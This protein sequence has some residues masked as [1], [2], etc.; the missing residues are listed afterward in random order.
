MSSDAMPNPNALTKMAA[1]PPRE[2]GIERASEAEEIPPDSSLTPGRMTKVFHTTR[3]P[4][5]YVKS[6]AVI[7]A[8]LVI[9]GGLKTVISGAGLPQPV[10]YIASV[11]ASACLLAL[12]EGALFRQPILRLQWT[13]LESGSRVHGPIVEIT[14]DKVPAYEL[15][16]SLEL[17]A[18]I[19][20]ILCR[21][22]NIFDIDIIICADNALKVDIFSQGQTVSATGGTVKYRLNAISSDTFSRSGE[23]AVSMCTSAFNA[24]KRPIHVDTT[25][26]PSFLR[27]F[28]RVESDVEFI[29][30]K[31][32]VKN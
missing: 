12:A 3:N 31:G 30:F 11:I 10:A 5:R 19:W 9:S 1:T 4:W 20:R 7:A 8:G 25:K 15:R 32:E 13:L 6:P 18:K 26:L 21:N 24:E 27:K 2:N 14:P 28:L 16:A 23:F 17:S 22:V 29:T